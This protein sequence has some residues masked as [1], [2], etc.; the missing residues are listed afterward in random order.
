MLKVIEIEKGQLDEL[1]Q[2]IYKEI[3]VFNE[4]VFFMLNLLE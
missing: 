4:K 1:N 2:I 3:D